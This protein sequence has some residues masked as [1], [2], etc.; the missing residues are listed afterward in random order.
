ML[1]RAEAADPSNLV[2]MPFPG[3]N[4]GGK[5]LGFWQIAPGAHPSHGNA[6]LGITAATVQQ[7]LDAITSTRQIANAKLAERIAAKSNH[8]E[9]VQE[10]RY[11]LMGLRTELD[12]LLDPD[13][14]RWYQFGCARP[15]DGRT[16]AKVSGLSLR[17]ELPVVNWLRSTVVTWR[18]SASGAVPVPAGLFADLSATLT[19]L[20]SGQAVFVAVSVRNATGETTPSEK[21]IVVP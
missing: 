11:R 5:G 9:S 7:T 17:A 3:T 13:D 21:S 1:P 12:Q 15:S 6:S 20:L 10:L 2:S 18:S 16:P 4:E 19:G 14:E 8:D